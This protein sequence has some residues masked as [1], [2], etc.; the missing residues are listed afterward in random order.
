MDTNIFSNYLL[1]TQVYPSII[2]LLLI[3]SIS[4]WYSY[5]VVIAVGFSSFGIVIVVGLNI[6]RLNFSWIWTEALSSSGVAL[7]SY[8]EIILKAVTYLP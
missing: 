1:S 4:V 3:V 6:F 2:R 5:V 8:P 7:Y